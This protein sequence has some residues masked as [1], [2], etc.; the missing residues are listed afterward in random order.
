MKTNAYYCRNYLFCGVAFGKNVTGYVGMS[1]GCTGYVKPH[2]C[3]VC[4]VRV[5]CEDDYEGLHL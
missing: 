2:L 4:I 3:V 1:V 5:Y